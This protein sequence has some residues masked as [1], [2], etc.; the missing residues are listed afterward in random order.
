M[1]TI[2]TVSQSVA[3]TDLLNALS[4][5]TEVGLFDVVDVAPDVINHFCDAM[6]EC[7]E[8]DRRLMQVTF[9]EVQPGEIKGL[10]VLKK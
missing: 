6:E 5:C 10:P 4:R 2:L 9:E 8:D 3:L 1:S 7:K